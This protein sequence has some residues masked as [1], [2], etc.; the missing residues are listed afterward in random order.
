MRSRLRRTGQRSATGHSLSLLL[1]LLIV[2]AKPA[3]WRGSRGLQDT[4]TRREWNAPPK[5]N[6]WQY[7]CPIEGCNQ[8]CQER[9]EP[10]SYIYCRRNH[11]MRVR[12]ELIHDPRKG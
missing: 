2:A 6:W 4:G 12:M 9:D 1:L 5:D 11:G 8:F 7:K 10:T 3:D